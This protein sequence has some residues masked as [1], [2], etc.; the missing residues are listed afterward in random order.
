MNKARMKAVFTG[1]SGQ[2]KRDEKRGR[3]AGLPAAGRGNI[4]WK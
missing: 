4:C 1:I 2:E 3:Q